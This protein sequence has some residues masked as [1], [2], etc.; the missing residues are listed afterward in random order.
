VKTSAHALL[1]LALALALTGCTVKASHAL[2]VSGL[3]VAS[4]AAVAPGEDTQ[5]RPAS[6][7]V[8]LLMFA[9]GWVLHQADGPDGGS[10]P[11]QR[12]YTV[13]EP[14]DASITLDA[15]QGEK[16]GI[17]RRLPADHALFTR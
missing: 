12:V 1:V 13:L 15:D 8:G 3:A 2:M 10:A 5:L 7:S 4:G 6:I 14:L 11:S 16:L 17:Y 9:A